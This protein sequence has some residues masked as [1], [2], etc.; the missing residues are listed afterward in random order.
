M[1]SRK[2]LRCTAALAAAAALFTGCAK[3][4]PKYHVD[5]GEKKGVFVDAEDAYE[6]GEEVRLKTY[7]VMDASPTVTADGVRLSPEYDGYAYLVYT[8]IM[9][10]HDI[11]VTY[12]LGGSDMLMQPLP[13][14]YDGDVGRLIDPPGTAYPGE[15]VILKLGLIFDVSTEVLVNGTAAQQTDGPDSDYLYYE[16]VMPYEDV[17]VEIRSKNI[18]AVDPE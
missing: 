2:L 17:T 18:S 10:D 4:A 3:S 15:T 13:I 5:Y 8:F 12:S 1:R 7:V 11:E 9:P 16:F 6:A 14:E